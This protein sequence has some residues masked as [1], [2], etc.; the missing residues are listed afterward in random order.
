MS[1]ITLPFKRHHQKQAM[2]GALT[3]C[4]GNVTQACK[5]VDIVR[6][7]HYN[8][9][10][11]D[12][13]YKAASEDIINVAIDHVESKMFEQ[14]DLGNPALIMMYLK[15]IGKKRGYVEKTEIVS[16]VTVTG[17]PVISFG[18]TSKKD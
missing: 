12:D 5:I 14:I 13:E 17:N 4:L 1:S 10:A 8:W 9:L 11:S 15:T 16:E 7:T 18:D 6:N 2:I 3:K